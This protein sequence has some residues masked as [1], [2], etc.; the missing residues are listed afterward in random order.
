MGKIPPHLLPLANHA[1]PL[2]RRLLMTGA[3]PFAIGRARA[4]GCD[5]QQRAKI[6]REW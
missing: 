5:L 6:M 4:D 1:S 2:P 3:L